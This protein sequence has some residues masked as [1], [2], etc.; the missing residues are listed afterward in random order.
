[1]I[2][3]SM[4]LLTPYLSFHL[5]IGSRGKAILD[6]HITA[7]LAS[8]KQDCWLAVAPSHASDLSADLLRSATTSPGGVADSAGAL[9]LTHLIRCRLATAELGDGVSLQDTVLKQV[10]DIVTT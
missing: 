5:I 9:S 10:G 8:L 4:A 2:P 1:M 6:V 3:L 7:F